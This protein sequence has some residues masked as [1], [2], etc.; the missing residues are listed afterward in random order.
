MSG[1]ATK[2]NSL[3]A[4][5]EKYGTKLLDTRKTTPGIRFMEKW[6]VKIGGGE[7]HRFGLYDAILIKDNHIDYCKGITN[8]VKKACDYV[9]KNG[10]IPIIVEVRH[11][12]ELTDSKI[13]KLNKELDK[14]LSYNKILKIVSTISSSSIAY[15]QSQLLENVKNNPQ[16]AIALCREFRDL[17]EKG[18]S[19]SSNIAINDVANMRITFANTVQSLINQPIS[20]IVMLIMLFM[21]SVKLSLIVFIGAPISLMVITVLANSIKRK[22]MRSSIQIAGTKLSNLII[23]HQVPI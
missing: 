4:M 7:N 14:V 22:A 13:K 17:N 21:I 20:L 10:K 9:Q 5:T 11:K 1:I 12:K 2:T 15:G 16:E 8:A 3:V 19:A 18:I 23:N 6:A